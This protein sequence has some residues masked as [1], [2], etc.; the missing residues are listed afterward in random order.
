MGQCFSHKKCDEHLKENW[1]LIGEN[2]VIKR[3]LII[4]MMMLGLSL[5]NQLQGSFRPSFP[6]FLDFE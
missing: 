2:K 4:M 3:S 6:A 1:H 5:L